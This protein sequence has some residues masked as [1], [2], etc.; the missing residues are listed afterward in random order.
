MVGVGLAVSLLKSS[1][2]RA[3]NIKPTSPN[4]GE[5]VALFRIHVN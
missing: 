2:M 4:S 3:E 1:V 5:V